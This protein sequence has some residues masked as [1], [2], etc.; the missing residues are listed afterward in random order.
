MSRD[1]SILYGGSSSASFSSTQEQKIRKE[2]REEKEDKR[3]KLKPVAEIVMK[4]L[5]TE[6]QSVMFIQNIDI[7]NSKDEKMLMIE[8]MARQKYVEYIKQLKNKL[9]IILREPKKP[10]K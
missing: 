9:D 7:A 3:G 10:K 6:M 2:K 8:M 5:D 1:D 4:E